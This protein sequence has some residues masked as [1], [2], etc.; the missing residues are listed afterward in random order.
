MESTVESLLANPRWADVNNAIS[1]L[2][3]QGFQRQL[4]TRYPLEVLGVLSGLVYASQI[5]S[6]WYLTKTPDASPMAPPNPEEQPMQLNEPPILL[7][8]HLLLLAEEQQ[9]LYID[10]DSS[11]RYV[12]L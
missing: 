7:D 10:H 2:F 8:E 4:W 1:C 12:P 9:V 5:V 11:L 3:W 6:A